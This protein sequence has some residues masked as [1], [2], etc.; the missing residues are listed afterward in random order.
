[1]KRFLAAG[2]DQPIVMPLVEAVLRPTAP[3]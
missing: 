1:M 2:A 3:G